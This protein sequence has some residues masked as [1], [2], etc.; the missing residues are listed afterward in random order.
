MPNE[1]METLRKKTLHNNFSP[2]ANTVLTK[3]DGV[4]TQKLPSTISQNL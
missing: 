4:G 3:T 2:N 1:L